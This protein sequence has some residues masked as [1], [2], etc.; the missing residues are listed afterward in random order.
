[1]KNTSNKKIF[2]FDATPAFNKY[3]NLDFIK[4]L[5][6]NKEINLKS[7]NAETIVQN[8]ICKF[9]TRKL[10]PILEDFDTIKIKFNNILTN[11]PA[12]IDAIEAKNIIEKENNKLF[13][14][15]LLR[16]CLNKTKRKSYGLDVCAILYVLQ[17]KIAAKDIEK[18][19]KYFISSLDLYNYL[20]DAV[21][22]LSENN[23]NIDT[24]F[25]L[26]IETLV[27]MLHRAV[28]LEDLSKDISLIDETYLGFNRNE[29]IKSVTHISPFGDTEVDTNALIDISKNH[30]KDMLIDEMHTLEDGR[31][32]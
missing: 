19:K 22:Q 12:E 5:Q 13:A 2:N 1:M 31:I 9:I 17:Q 26:P 30:I 20:H 16:F 14:S 24:Y 11:I 7:E 3:V 4:K 15:Y 27:F 28:I 10:L 8:L 23:I 6:T 18:S 32:I 21:F 25:D 29:K